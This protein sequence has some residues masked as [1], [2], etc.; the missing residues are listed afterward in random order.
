[1]SIHKLEPHMPKELGSLVIPVEDRKMSMELAAEMDPVFTEMLA[2]MGGHNKFR[3]LTS[4]HTEPGAEGSNA[5]DLVYR[6][7]N[8]ADEYVLGFA[9]NALAQQRITIAGARTREEVINALFP[10]TFTGGN[11]ANFLATGIAINNAVAHNGIP[12]VPSTVI[13]PDG[14]Q[15]HNELSALRDKTL[16]LMPTGL[17]QS[18]RS[19]N[20]PCKGRRETA[21]L[22]SPYQDE[23]KIR[24]VLALFMGDMPADAHL[25]LHDRFDELAK[26]RRQYVVPS[27]GTLG[28]L[29][30]QGVKE[31]AYINDVELREMYG[32]EL[33]SIIAGG[34]FSVANYQET[35]NLMRT[36]WSAEGEDGYVANVGMRGSGALAVYREAGRLYGIETSLMSKQAEGELVK[37]AN[38]PDRLSFEPIDT[39]GRGDSAAAGAH[40]FRELSPHIIEAM[41]SDPDAP[42]LQPHQKALA[43]MIAPELCARAAACLVFHQEHSHLLG[44]PPDRLRAV[45]AKL[46]EQAIACAQ[47][48]SKPADA[49]PQRFLSEYGVHGVVFA[50]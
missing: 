45:F 10:S 34:S 5:M 40:F 47:E 18:R 9:Q 36:F 20:L 3:G 49:Q 23:T 12:A 37:F 28:K 42:N 38:V 16:R 50:V 7:E 41:M 44:M 15:L 13:L 4:L 17:L 43:A 2:S 24:E 30:K 26:G 27:N 48:L 29:A 21:L 46:H 11:Q 14:S 32:L 31:D 25:L 35:V 1:M 8:T 39:V 19:L 22:G 33:K 6:P